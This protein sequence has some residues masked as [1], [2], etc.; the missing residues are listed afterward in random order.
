MPA[1]ILADLGACSCKVGRHA[2]HGAFAQAN[3]ERRGVAKGG[4]NLSRAKAQSAQRRGMIDFEPKFAT[5][6]E[7]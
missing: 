3:A 4:E 7:E 5:L 6:S 2:A 1:I